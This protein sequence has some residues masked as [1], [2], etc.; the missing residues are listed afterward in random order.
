MGY[1]AAIETAVPEYCHLKNATTSFFQNSVEDE[2]IK[3]KIKIIADKSGIDS[4]YSVIPDF[5]KESKDFT[6]FP[7]NKSLEPSPLLTD[8]MNVFKENAT[9]LSIQAIKKIKNFDEIKNTI[10]HLITVLVLVYLLQV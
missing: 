2:S 10:T 1:I 6:F 3:R 8:R 7:K 5:S 4:R 9:K